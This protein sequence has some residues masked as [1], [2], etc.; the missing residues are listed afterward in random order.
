MAVNKHI[1]TAIRVVLYIVVIAY[2]IAPDYAGENLRNLRQGFES[3]MGANLTRVHDSES[4]VTDPTVLK[5]AE[6]VI[7]LFESQ[8]AQRSNTTALADY[9]KALVKV[10]KLEE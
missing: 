2:F 5:D 4:V 8:T 6:A 10:H 3:Y 9:V 7:S 1:K